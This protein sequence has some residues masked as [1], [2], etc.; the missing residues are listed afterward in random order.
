[1]IIRPDDAWLLFM[2]QHDHARLAADLLS[3]WTADGFPNHPRRDALLLAAREHDN[4]W[5]DIDDGPAFDSASGAPLD[6][7]S[8]ADQTKRG[9]WP[10]AIE[11]VAQVSPYAAA[12]IA[13]HA[14]SIY[15]SHA[16]DS[17]WRP[18]FQDMAGRRDQLIEHT[19]DASADLQSDYRFL[20]I[21]DLL[22]L[23]FCNA[24]T[25][26]RERYGCRVRYAAE[27]IDVTPAPFGEAVPLRIR[28]RRLPNRRYAS[29]ADL[30]AA[31]EEAAPE[32]IEGLARGG[33]AS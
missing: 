4:G 13:Q 30:R 5:R 19:P 1:M 9:L 24:W 11:R 6:F 20:S 3:H 21:V 22:S 31:F 26:E 32:I 12:L 14:I 2:T 18:F 23:S 17:S 29:T 8:I 28:A 33:A 25:D 16:D 27:G 15:D 10:G 7:I